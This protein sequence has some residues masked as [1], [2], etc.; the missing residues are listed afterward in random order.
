MKLKDWLP[1]E[2]FYEFM[3][4]KAAK[5]LEIEVIENNSLIDLQDKRKIWQCWI[6][7]EKYVYNWVRLANGYAVGWNE[8]PSRGW[9]FPVKKF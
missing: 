3:D 5:F 7:K 2:F 6:G 8:N 1:K 4:T 9:S